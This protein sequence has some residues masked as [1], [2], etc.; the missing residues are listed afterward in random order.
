MEEIILDNDDNRMVYV[1]RERILWFFEDCFS[2]FKEILYNNSID[3]TIKPMVVVISG[4]NREIFRDVARDMKLSG[5]Y[6][7]HV[8]KDYS[9]C[10]FTFVESEMIMGRGKKDIGCIVGDLL[11]VS[12]SQVSKHFLKDVNIYN[13][14]KHWYDI[15]AR[16]VYF[17]GVRVK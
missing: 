11:F 8:S 9:S 5:Y 4:I 17:N 6:W 14:F 16:R 12:D 2:K 3:R 15:D 13:V 7:F 1:K 10:I